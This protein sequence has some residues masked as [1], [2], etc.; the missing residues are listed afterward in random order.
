MAS[1]ATWDSETSASTCRLSKSASEAMPPFPALPAL[2]KP[3]TISPTSVSF[4]VIRP[5]KGART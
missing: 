1:F 5:E 4:C 3:K 2:V